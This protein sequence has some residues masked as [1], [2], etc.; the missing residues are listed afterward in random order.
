MFSLLYITLNLEY[1]NV[2]HVVIYSKVLYKFTHIHKHTYAHECIHTGS[3]A[4]I[5]TYI[6]MFIWTYNGHIKIMQT[7]AHSSMYTYVATYKNTHLHINGH[8]FIAM[9]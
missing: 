6:N 3:H 9:W 5:H 1:K 4:D 2:L 7:E 8:V